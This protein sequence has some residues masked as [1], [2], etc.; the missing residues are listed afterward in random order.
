MGNKNSAFE[1]KVKAKEWQYELAREAKHLDKEI[2]KLQKN[3]QKLQAKIREQAEKGNVDSVQMLARTVVQSRRA[4]Q[5]LEKTKMSME[6]VKLQLTTSM[7]SVGTANSIKLSAEIM[8]KMNGIARIPEVSQNMEEM[9]KQMAMCAD[10]E[11]SIE[12]ALRLPGEESEADTEVQRILEEMALDQMGP[13]ANV[14]RLTPQQSPPVAAAPA[15][16]RQPIAVGAAG[17]YVA[18]AAAPAP[19]SAPSVSPAAPAAAAA[20]PLAATP[21]DVS[22]PA[23]PPSAQAQ[24]PLSAPSAPA[25]AASSGADDDLMRRLEMLKKS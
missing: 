17:G 7:A 13:L 23:M 24:A 11:D 10:A 4:V 3:E 1:A 21:Q 12:D 14:A 8:K 6:A 20:A 19:V 16:E 22:A 18:P 9:R 5:R 25:P 15:A 2:V